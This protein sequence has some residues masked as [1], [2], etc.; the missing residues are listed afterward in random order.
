[1]ISVIIKFRNG[2]EDFNAG[3]FPSVEAFNI[4]FAPYIDNKIFGEADSVKTEIIEISPAV[5]ENGEEI[6]ELGG[7]SYNPP[8][9]SQ[10][11]VVPAVTETITTPI[12]GDYEVVIEDITEQYNRELLAQEKIAKGQA[13]REV[14]QKVLD[15]VAGANLDRELT[16]EQITDLQQTFAQAESAL[17]AGRPTFAKIFISAI[18][19]DG[20]LVTEEIKSNCL[21]LLAGY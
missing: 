4:W 14:C 9:Y 19:P 12:Q 20:V 21:E 13:A 5:Y 10:I 8:Q 1:M 3:R 2:K 18:E 16:I 7:A 15:Y 17:R 11:L 6:F